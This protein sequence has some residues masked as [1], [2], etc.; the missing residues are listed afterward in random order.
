METKV[1]E[2]IREEIPLI[3]LWILLIG[4]PLNIILM[5]LVCIRFIWAKYRVPGVGRLV[6]VEYLP[7]KKK[8]VMIKYS[9]T[10]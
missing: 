7:E 3:H 4:G 10:F 5:S 2:S 8:K 9:K 6:F 1:M